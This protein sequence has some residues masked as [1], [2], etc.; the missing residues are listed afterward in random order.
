MVSL[1]G[2]SWRTLWPVDAAQSTIFFRSRNSPTPKSSSLLRENTG[3]AVPAP[4]HCLPEKRGCTEASTKNSPLR[5]RNPNT[6]FSP[7][8][9]TSGFKVSLSAIT[10]LYMNGSVTSSGS[11]HTGNEASSNGITRLHFPKALVLA[12]KASTSPGLRTGAAT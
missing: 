6:R 12:A 5:G 10:S 8:S 4:F 11:V 7:S 1:I 9:Q 3:I 2:S